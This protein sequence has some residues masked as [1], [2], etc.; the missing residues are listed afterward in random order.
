M[1]LNELF[2][3]PSDT[4]AV[5]FGRFNPPHKGHKAAW[6]LMRKDSSNWFV[7]TNASTQGPK[8]PL[9]YDV[10]IEAMK[11]VDPAVEAHL[12]SSQSWL[13]MISELYEK[14][15]KAKLIVYTD[16]EW[17]VKTI[18][19]YNGIEGKAHGFYNYASIE[20]KPTPR[21]SSATELRAAVQAGDREAF[22]KAAG[23]DADT[24]IAGKAYFDL[25]AE[26][27]LPY[28][29]KAK[30]KTKEDQSA[31]IAHTAKDLANPDSAKVMKHRAKRDQEREQQLKGRN[32]AKRDN[33]EKDEWGNYKK[34]EAEVQES[35][36]A[37]VILDTGERKR[38]R[39]VPTKKDVVDTIVRYYLKQG[40]RVTKV[41]NTEIEWK[42]NTTG[43]KNEEAAGV[44]IITK[45][46]TTKDV[47]KGTL[48]KMMKGYRLI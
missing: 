8:D 26:Y 47:N 46:N 3:A 31:A 27:L 38:I 18:N 14:H 39:Y 20:H 43:N 37:D 4:L 6:E 24:E 33:T 7:G 19:Q 12:M 2:E 48:R 17:V 42:P 5:I 36:V 22:T 15:P 16:E 28:G 45:Q 9:P 13:T 23:I 25:V 40:L 29:D 11:A 1:R 21:V 10:K 44:G 41:N 34:E 35:H 32:I 30:K